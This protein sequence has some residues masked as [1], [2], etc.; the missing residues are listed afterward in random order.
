MHLR[1]F[2][3]LAAAGVV[4]CLGASRPAIAQDADPDPAAKQAEK[5]AEK[6]A[7]EKGL[8][9]LEL[10]LPKPA[11]KGTPKHVP[12]GANL[13]PPRKGPRP[14]FFAPKGT[15]SVS[16]GKPVTSS[17]MEPI[18]GEIKFVTDGG[19]EAESGAYVE[20]GPGVQWVQIDLKE[21][22]AIQAL[23]VWHYHSNARVYHDVIIQVSNDKSFINDVKTVYNNDHDNSAGM[24][25]GKEKEYWET[26]E[27]RLIDVG[28]AKGRYVRLY[29]N[30]STEDDMNHYTEVEVF[31]TP[32]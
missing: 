7:R 16:E 32:K 15:R 28:G 23:L 17:D 5:D 24:G 27:G 9:P 20:L 6:A 30:G 21:E 19:K 14:T 13:E 18:I 1:I 25:I 10:K 29:S 31:A 26:F 22:V 4:V 12:P 8:V 2:R 11:F 3:Y